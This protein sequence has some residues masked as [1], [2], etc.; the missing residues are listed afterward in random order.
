MMTRKKK[1]TP[2][3]FIRPLVVTV[4]ASGFVVMVRR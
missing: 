2:R 3:P 4:D 1:P